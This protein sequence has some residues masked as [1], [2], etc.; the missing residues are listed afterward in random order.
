MKKLMFATFILFCIFASVSAFFVET[1]NQQVNGT[2]VSEKIRKNADKVESRSND[3]F[4]DSSGILRMLSTFKYL[5]SM[6]LEFRSELK[7]V[8]CISDH[9]LKIDYFM[10][11][12]PTP[13]FSNK[14]I[15]ADKKCDRPEKNSISSYQDGAKCSNTSD[16]TADTELP[17]TDTRVSLSDSESVGRSLLPINGVPESFL[18]AI[19]GLVY[20][21]RWIE[22]LID[23]FGVL[24][25]TRRYLWILFL[26]W[27]DA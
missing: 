16:S 26:R 5:R 27:M 10:D 13:R 9:F 17:N 19:G 15:E 12:I 2:V 3:E 24:E 22:D 11:S 25:C 14:S 6:Y 8:Y 20:M 18:V 4:D 7:F 1:S 23:S 21:K